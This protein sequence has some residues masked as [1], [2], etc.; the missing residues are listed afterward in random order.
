MNMLIRRMGV[1]GIC[2][3]FAIGAMETFPLLPN[4]TLD[5]FR[6]LGQQRSLGLRIID[7]AYVLG[8]RPIA[9]HAQALDAIQKSIEP[10]EQEQKILVSGGFSDDINLLLLQ[11]QPDFSSI[12]SAVHIIIRNPGNIDPAQLTILATHEN[13]YFIGMSL[14]LSLYQDK[15]HSLTLSYFGIQLALTVMLLGCWLFLIK[16]KGAGDSA[17]LR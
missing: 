6:L 17:P 2:L 14:A 13:N 16:K 4:N 12:D 10:W 9:E 11:T 3:F 5:T 1:F 15:I 8:Y 7:N